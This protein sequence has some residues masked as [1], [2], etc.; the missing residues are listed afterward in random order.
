MTAVGVKLES[1]FL[2]WRRQPVSTSD[3]LRR[4]EVIQVG[5]QLTTRLLRAC[6]TTAGYCLAAG[7]A[8]AELLYIMQVR[9]ARVSVLEIH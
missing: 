1:A 8:T 3:Y 6:K 5:A 4:L 9:L 7:H 2:A